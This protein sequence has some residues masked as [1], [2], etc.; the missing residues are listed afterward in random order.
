MCT[1]D[2]NIICQVDA[3]YNCYNDGKSHYGYL[4]SLGFG[5]AP[6]CLKSSKIKLVTLSSTESEYVAL[7][8]A[9]REGLFYIRLLGELGFYNENNPITF[10][11][12]NQGVVNMMKMEQLNHNTTKHIA[13]KFHFV[14]DLF[15]KQIINIQKIHTKD[16]VA[17]LL[18]KALPVTL[19][20][21]FSEDMLNWH[22]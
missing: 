7:A 16:N 20:T 18:T 14:R 2:K 1:T 12:D 8:F 21:R 22:Y 4:F 6:F 3:S 13:P 17:D 9:V 5:N 11:E 15:K 10:F 19:F